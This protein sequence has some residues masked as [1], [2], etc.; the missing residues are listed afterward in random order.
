MKNK[1]KLWTAACLL[2]STTAN[3]QEL[4]K[5]KFLFH[6]KSMEYTLFHFNQKCDSFKVI[7][8]DQ[9]K[10]SQIQESTLRN[11]IK[12]KNKTP[13]FYYVVVP[14][15][16]TTEKEE[17]AMNAL[18]SI[19]SKSMLSEKKLEIITDSECLNNYEVKRQNSIEIKKMIFKLTKESLEL[20]KV[21]T[22]ESNEKLEQISKKLAELKDDKSKAVYANLNSIHKIT[23]LKP[24]EDICPYLN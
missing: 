8:L 5:N 22:A 20:K 23:V 18:I 17:Y 19:S 3:A 7:I 9:E 1:F 2:L 16:F 4:K 6:N 11:C 13:N 10:A 24:K 15:E 14:S 21:N 12:N